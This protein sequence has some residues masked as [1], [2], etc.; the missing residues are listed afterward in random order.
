MIHKIM[1][2]LELVKAKLTEVTADKG[3]ET[4]SDAT[5]VNIEAKLRE[6]IDVI[7][8]LPEDERAALKS[9][10]EDFKTFVEGR[11]QEAEE[12]ITTFKEKLATSQSS[13]SAMKAYGSLNK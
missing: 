12:A 11:Q 4:D 1:Q 9:T 2:E 5:F 8:K 13:K 7:L 6:L 3:I 10:V